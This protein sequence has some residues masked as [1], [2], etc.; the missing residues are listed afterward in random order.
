MKPFRDID[1][2]LIWALLGSLILPGES[3]FSPKETLG[4][5]GRAS[6]NGTQRTPKYLRR[7]A[8]TDPTETLAIQCLDGP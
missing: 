4:S 8:K 3:L 5:A 7:V 2:G 6:A 1:E